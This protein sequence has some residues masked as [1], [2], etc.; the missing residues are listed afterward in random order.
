MSIYR[1]KSGRYAVLIDLDPTSTGGRRRR[2]LG[3]YPTRKEAERAERDALSARDRG[4]DLAPQTV[5]IK[6]LVER[7]L[8]ERSARWSTKTRERSQEIAEQYIIPHLGSRTLAKLRPAHVAEWC[9]VL[10]ER[11]GRPVRRGDEE[12]RNR[13]LSPKTVHHAFMLLK[14]AFG[15]GVK[16]QLATLNPLVAVDSPKVPR[17]EAQAFTPEEVRKLLDAAEG[18]RWQNLVLFALATG[19]RRGEIAALRWENVNMESAS[20]TVCASLCDTRAGVEEKLTKTEKPRI[21]PLSAMAADAL[22]RQRIAQAQASR[23]TSGYCDTGHVFQGP[24]GGS[25][26]PYDITDGFRKLAR[27]AGV[28]IT[29]FHALRHTAAT[30]M[31]VSGVDV[32]STAGVLGHSTASTTLGIYAHVVASAQAA[33]VATIDERL[34][35]ATA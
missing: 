26:R 13:P 22:R 7:F 1:R 11:G 32:R 20:I 2:S 21:V 25:I 16:M 15:W 8:Q 28:A 34:R 29:S 30:W 19:A 12:P 9:T 31:L 4:I 33:A 18:T 27:K 6:A 14:A 10:R 35:A 3:T 5:T 24:A 17:R 23:W